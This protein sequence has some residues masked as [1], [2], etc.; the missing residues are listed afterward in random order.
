MGP[1]WGEYWG[2]ERGGSPGGICWAEDG[3]G[4]QEAKTCAMDNLYLYKYLYKCTLGWPQCW[5][6]APNAL[7]LSKLITANIVTTNQKGSPAN[8]VGL[9]LQLFGGVTRFTVCVP[10]NRHL[11]PH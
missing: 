6:V 11:L 7:A 1:G 9:C 10:S 5:T 4:E 3:G 8:T 2:E